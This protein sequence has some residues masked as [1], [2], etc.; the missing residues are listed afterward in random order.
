M[1]TI[2]YE[3]WKR[4]KY[5]LAA[6]HD[7]N[8]FNRDTV[9]DIIFAQRLRLNAEAFIIYRGIEAGCIKAQIRLYLPRRARL[10][11]L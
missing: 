2:Y 4:D 7:F 10:N 3:E 5:N 9:T 8:S 6:V 11:R 1:E